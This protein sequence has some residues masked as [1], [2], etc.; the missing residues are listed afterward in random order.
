MC[1][2]IPQKTLEQEL[3]AVRAHEADVA[4]RAQQLELSFE[5]RVHDDFERQISDTVKRTCTDALADKSSA[6]ARVMQA[7]AHARACEKQA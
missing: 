3:S 6:E 4:A 2:H 7:V 1:F 5:Q